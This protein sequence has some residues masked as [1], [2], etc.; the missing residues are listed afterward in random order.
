LGLIDSQDQFVVSFESMN[1]PVLRFKNNTPVPALGLGTWQ[2]EGQTCLETVTKAL[3]LGYKHIDTA[4]IY[5]NEREVGQAIRDSKVPRQ[6]IFVTAKVW[7]TQ[8]GFEQVKISARESLERLGLDYVDLLL[9]H[10]PN[11]EIPL[12]ETLA[13]FQ[14]LKDEGK[15]GNFGVSNFTTTH[16]QEALELNPN[17]MTNQVEFHP[18]FNQ[19]SLK[20]FCDEHG[21]LVSAYSPIGRGLD[22]QLPTIQEISQKRQVS[23]SQVIINWCLQKGMMVIPKASSEEHLQ[24]NLNSLSWRL[25]DSEIS[26][27]DS[28]P[29][30]HRQINP[31]FAEFDRV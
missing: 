12:Q 24:D 11:Q 31:E 4:A 7:R 30:N 20:T 25:D 5:G 26:Q 17:I 18:S 14:E 15:I 6:Q 19:K 27:I 28:I 21:I 29:D 3:Q 16:I 2:L 13:A 9:A 23:P 8:L 10:W 1:Y 22:L